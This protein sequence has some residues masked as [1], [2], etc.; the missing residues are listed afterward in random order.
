MEGN[1]DRTGTPPA[2][3]AIY[4]KGRAEARLAKIQRKQIGNRC[5]QYSAVSAMSLLLEEDI[6][7]GSLKSIVDAHPWKYSIFGKKED[8]TVKQI[9]SLI[10]EF[11]TR[12]KLK[13]KAV[14][15]RKKTISLDDLKAI[16][17]DPDRAAIISVTWPKS[18]GAQPGIYY[19]D[20]GRSSQ[21]KMDKNFLMGGHFMVAAAF[22]PN[23][24]SNGNPTPWGFINSNNDGKKRD[25]ENISWMTESDFIRTWGA[26][27]RYS[28]IVISKS[29]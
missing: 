12:E 20:S 10:N 26:F 21:Y 8:A 5:G 6:D 15:C 14:L 27:S 3:K 17:S 11:A 16:I 23:H 24:K 28:T 13:I 1:T 4:E 25:T 29:P 7:P 18:R 19:G 9:E 22:D 2:T